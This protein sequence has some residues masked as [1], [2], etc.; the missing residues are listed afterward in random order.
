MFNLRRTA[1][2][3]DAKIVMGTIKDL[4]SYILRLF[5][6]I[7]SSSGKLVDLEVEVE[8]GIEDKGG[9]ENVLNL[10]IS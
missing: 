1:V 7:T 3:R 4:G 9:E 2:A 8:V 6:S 10:R 5:S